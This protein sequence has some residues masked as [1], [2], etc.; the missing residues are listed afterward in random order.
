MLTNRC[1][2]NLA[3]ASELIDW[4]R[5]RWEIEMV[6][7]VLKNGCQVDEL[8]LGAIARIERALVLY[9]IVSW[10]IAHLVRMGRT[11]PELD[12]KLF[13]DP[14][15]IQAAYLFQKTLAQPNPTINDVIRLIAKRGG[16]LGRKRDGEPGAKTL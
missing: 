4:Y 2:T 6:F 15:E 10:R 7:N 12:A 11:C 16:F 5:A 13:F 8:Q 3:E 1:A 14:D 9:L